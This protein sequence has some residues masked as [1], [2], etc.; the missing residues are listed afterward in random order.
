M[1]MRERMLSLKSTLRAEI[2]SG[3]KMPTTIS[4]ATVKSCRNEIQYLMIV[5]SPAIAV[6]SRPLPIAPSGLRLLTNRNNPPRNSNPA[7]VCSILV[8]RAWCN[9]LVRRSIATG[10]GR[11]CSSRTEPLIVNGRGTVPSSVEH[12]H[13]RRGFFACAG[14]V[15]CIDEMDSSCDLVGIKC[16]SRCWL[17]A[18]EEPIM[19]NDTRIAVDVAKAVFELAISD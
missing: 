17:R 8:A 15:R 19:S 6:D 14:L 1:P 12:T 5:S 4:V 10:A 9:A 2:M 18:K 11:G 3:P 7:A 13:Q 16:Q